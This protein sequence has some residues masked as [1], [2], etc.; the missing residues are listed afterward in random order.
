[1]EHVAN[2]DHFSD[3]AEAAPSIFSYVS[4]H[5]LLGRQGLE[6][7]YGMVDQQ[8]TRAVAKFSCVSCPG[9]QKSV[10]WVTAATQL[11]GSW[12]VSHSVG[13]MD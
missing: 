11:D 2:R 12:V 9:Y 4:A 5:P 3:V 7:E 1:M 6:F 10:I 13:W 8:S